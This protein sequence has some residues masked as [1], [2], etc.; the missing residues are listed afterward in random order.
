MKNDIIKGTKV[1]KT[2]ISV[3]Y[4][5]YKL[6]EPSKLQ[7]TVHS[8]SSYLLTALHLELLILFYD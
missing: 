1:C 3:S 5:L 7:N 8:T 2:E 6:I 4:D